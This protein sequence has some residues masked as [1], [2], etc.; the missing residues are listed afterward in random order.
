M[1]ENF[2]WFI[3][4]ICVKFGDIELTSALMLGMFCVP[5][6]A[7]RMSVVDVSFVAHLLKNSVRAGLVIT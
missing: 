2:Y 6:L 1:E 5:R 4:I 3:T 7:E